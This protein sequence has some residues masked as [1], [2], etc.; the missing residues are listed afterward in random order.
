MPNTTNG[1]TKAKK[2]KMGNFGI[3][4]LPTWASFRGQLGH[5]WPLLIL[6]FLLK[7]DQKL[8]GMAAGS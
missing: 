5:L 6:F 2:N 1:P 8:A 4:W 7:S 3:F